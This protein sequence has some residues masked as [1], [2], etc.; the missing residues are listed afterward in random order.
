[1][2]SFKLNGKNIIAKELGFGEMCDMQEIGVDIT[3]PNYGSAALIRAYVAIC[4]GISK[5]EAGEEIEQHIMNGGDLNSVS[6]AIHDA[7]ENSGFFRKLKE[8]A[9]KEATERK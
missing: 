6:K 2:K 8:N 7:I 5:E 4:L 9:E 3:K 1:M